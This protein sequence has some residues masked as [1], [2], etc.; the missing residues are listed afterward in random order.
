MTLGTRSGAISRRQFMVR[1]TGALA[2]LITALLSV[3]AVGFLL[4]PLWSPAQELWVTVQ[5][6]PIDDIAEGKPTAR[7]AAVPVGTGPATPPVNR[8]VYVVKYQ[9]QLYAFSNICTHM[10]CDV[11]WDPSLSLFE[12]PCHGGLYAINGRNVGGPP[13]QPLPQ[14]VHRTHVQDGKTYLQIANKLAESI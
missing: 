14:W 3:P 2:G 5:G 11:H 12:C 7:I 13:P 1:G 6:G 9:G 10:Q 8:V 4:S